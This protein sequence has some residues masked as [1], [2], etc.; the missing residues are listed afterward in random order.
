ML[1]LGRDVVEA[2]RAKLLSLALVLED[3][4]PLNHGVGFVRAVP[5]YGHVHLFGRTDQ[6][7]RRV[8]LGSTRRIE[9]CGAS[10]PNSGTIVCYLKSSSAAPM[11]WEAAQVPGVPALVPSTA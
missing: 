4:G 5:V 11:A 8:G 6:Q 7:L 9:I 3:G 10:F 2:A 1:H